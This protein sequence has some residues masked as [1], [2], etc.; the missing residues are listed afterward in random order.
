MV[1]EAQYGVVLRGEPGVPPVVSGATVLPAVRFDNQAMFQADEI[2]DV[3]ADGFLAFEF[4]V[5]EAFC[6]QGFGVFQQ[7]CVFCCPLPRP[8]SRIRERGG[9]TGGW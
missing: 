5:A 4:Q 9:D 8:F 2:N 7:A 1:P 3:G 6:A